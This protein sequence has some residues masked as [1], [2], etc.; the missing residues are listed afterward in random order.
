MG[1]AQPHRPAGGTVG[2]D[3]PDAAQEP[4]DDTELRVVHPLPPKHADADGE[5]ERDHHE[6]A[7]E[8][9]SPEGLEQ[10]KRETGAE[11]ALEDGSHH[12]EPDAVAECDVEDVAL[13]SRAKVLQPHEARR[14]VGDRRIAQ[15]QKEREQERS[16]HEEQDVEDGRREQEVAEGESPGRL[17]REPP[18]RTRPNSDRDG[19]GPGA[20]RLRAAARRARGHACL[21]LA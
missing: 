10:E 17:A 7:D 6:A 4:V 5:R 14:R 20:C 19:G 9:P 11:Q 12:R 2:P 18:A 16:S 3:D 1:L 13:E 15:R 21:Y 8:L